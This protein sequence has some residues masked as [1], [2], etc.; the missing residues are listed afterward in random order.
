MRKLIL[1]SAKFV[2]QNPNFT[3][4]LPTTCDAECPFCSWNSSNQNLVT[5][6]EH[7]K[8]VRLLDIILMKLPKRITSITIS[9]GEPGLF[10]ALPELMEVLSKHKTINIKKIVYTTNGKNLGYL[11]SKNWFTD[12]IDFINLSRHSDSQTQNDKIMKIQSIDW[13]EI[14]KCSTLLSYSGIP[15]NIN[16]VLSKKNNV[17]YDF[18]FIENFIKVCKENYVSSIVFRNDYDD[19]FKKHDLEV[20]LNDRYKLKG[21][22]ECPVCRKAE[23]IINGFPIYFTSSLFEPVETFGTNIYELIM[24][25]NGVLTADWGGE[26]EVDYLTQSNST[27]TTGT[28]SRVRIEPTHSNPELPDW[29]N[30]LPDVTEEDRENIR[31][32]S[33]SYGCSSGC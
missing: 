5:R 28:T 30:D 32:T 15:L 17:F 19:G 33:V 26:V 25:P 4:V 23:Y 13:K 1:D 9:G 24:Q 18:D 12:V 10:K 21:L 20:M 2:V 27:S 22:G 11:S 7:F 6:E 3:I 29:I 16:C 14:K 31:G 8:Y